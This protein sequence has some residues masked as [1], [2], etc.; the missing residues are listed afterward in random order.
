M[1]GESKSYAERLFKYPK[2]GALE[3]KDARAALLGP[4]RE[5]GARIEEAALTA[6][7][8]ITERYPYFLQQWG[9][10]AWNVA[11]HDMITAVD[12]EAATEIAIRKLDDNFFRVRFDRCTPSEKRYMRALAEFGPGTHRS[13][14]VADR[15]GLKTTSVGPVRNKLIR[16]GMIY[17]PQH[18][19]TAFT[20]PLFDAY[21]RRVIPTL[22]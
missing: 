2:I 5:E 19:D 21:L 17:S 11:E 3:E 7:L 10:D 12:V 14:D 6:I 1:A 9:H 16:K 8:E 22:D 20:V 18:G 13:G 4:I 15:L